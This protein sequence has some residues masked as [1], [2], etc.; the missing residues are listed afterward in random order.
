[1]KIRQRDIVEVPFNMPEGGVLNHPVIVLSQ[2]DVIVD[3]SAF[4]GVMLSS[5]NYNDLYSFEITQ[6]M[7]SKKPNKDHCEA[8]LHLVSLFSYNDVINNTFHNQIKSVYFR[9]LIEQIF[10]V[11]FGQVI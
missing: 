8:R 4:I 11:A 9:G 3:E 6:D 2:D 10:E 1:M 5:Q 7:L